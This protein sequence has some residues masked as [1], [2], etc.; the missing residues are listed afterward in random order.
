MG[1]GISASIASHCLDM[2]EELQGQGMNEEE[3]KKISGAV[4]F[5]EPEFVEHI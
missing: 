4:Y 3:I 5:G 1:E 2:L